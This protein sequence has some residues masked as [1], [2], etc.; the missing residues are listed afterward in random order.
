MTAPEA[1]RTRRSASGRLGRR[2]RLGRT[3][4]ARRWRQSLQFRALAVALSLTALAFFVTG[5]FLSHQIADR[6]FSDR[7]EQ[8][9]AGASA[10][11]EDVQASFDASDAADRDELQALAASTLGALSTDGSDAQRRWILVPMD[12]TSG[13]ALIPAQSQSPWMTSSTVPPELQERLAAQDGV[14]WQPASV[15]MSENGDEVPVIV[16]GTVVELQQ[17]ARYGLYL[18]YDFSDPQRTLDAMHA[19]LLL[20]VVVL[21]LLVGAIVWYVTREVVRPV[22]ST[23]RVAELLAEGDL[24]VRMP[25]SGA[26]EVARLARSFNRMAD[27]LQ[28]QI[29]QLE[30]LS[31]M[32]QT[33]VSDVSHEL[34]T[35]LTT[36]RMAAEVLFNAREDFDPVNRRSAELLY[37]QVD[38]FDALLADLLE[39]S[40]FDAGAARLEVANVELFSVIQDVVEAAAPLAVSSGSVITVRSG[41]TRCTVQ[42]DPRRLERILRNLVVNALEHG[43]GRPVEVVVAEADAVVAVAVRDHGIGMTEEE[44][45]KVFNR[46][47]RADPARARTT[48]GTGLGLAIATEDTRLHGGRLDVW[49]AP[50]EG[51]CFRLTLPRVQGRRLGPEDPSPLPLPPAAA[52]LP[53]RAGTTPTGTLVLVP[54]PAEPAGPGTGPDGAAAGDR[55]G[56]PPAADPVPASGPQTAAPAPEEPAAGRPAQ[57]PGAPPPGGAAPGGAGPQAPVRADGPAGPRP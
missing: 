17:N 27:S 56:E 43:E 19:V 37:H 57:A 23:A 5:S 3:L 2:L 47:W 14:Y 54:G 35:P 12:Y 36:V 39:I 1:A 42:G 31:S 55:A 44:A 52:E 32:Q 49:G 8:V 34:R 28:E 22:T 10:D 53:E 11:F 45:E 20:S 29:V 16:V 51:A 24:G 38:R 26:H 46:F 41:L 48:G 50:G 6:L 15:P 30:H 13:Q 40:R 33:F 7:L 9:L 21:L 25:V 18:V 4:V